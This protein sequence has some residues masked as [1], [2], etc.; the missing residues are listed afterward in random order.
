[1]S[2]EAEILIGV[3]QEVCDYYSFHFLSIIPK[4]KGRKWKNITGIKGKVKKGRMGATWWGWLSE[5]N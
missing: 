5:V 2:D 4:M 1:M 3:P